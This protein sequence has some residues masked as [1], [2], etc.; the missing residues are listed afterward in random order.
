M[1]VS[2]TICRLW[3]LAQTPWPE[4][5]SRARSGAGGATS[6]AQAT[7]NS[8]ATSSS[9]LLMGGTDDIDTREGDRCATR[10]RRHVR[11]DPQLLRGLVI[12][13]TIGEL[14]GDALG[15]TVVEGDVQQLFAVHGTSIFVLHL[16]NDL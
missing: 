4:R 13:E 5:A 14:I 7:L 3:H 6:A 12:A 10:Q 11:T 1:G 15:V 2:I 16:A 9:D 8:A